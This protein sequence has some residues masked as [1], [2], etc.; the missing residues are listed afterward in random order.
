MNSKILV[1]EARPEDYPGFKR[2]EKKAWAGTDIPVISE[3]MFNVWIKVFSEGL[4]LA[5]INGEVCGHVY[6]QVCDF[7]PFDEGDQRNL[8]IMTDNMYTI[9]THNMAG[10]C[11]YSF[12]ISAPG[13]FH[14]ETNDYYVYKIMNYRYLIAPGLEM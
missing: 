5:F 6:S 10:N 11:I 1:R 2:M 14:R 3:K 8:N 4:R 9:K 12:S 7:D 13:L